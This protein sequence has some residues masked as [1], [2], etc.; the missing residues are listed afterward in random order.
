MTFFEHQTPRGVFLA[1]ALGLATLAA[2]CADVQTGRDPVAIANGVRVTSTGDD[3][4]RLEVQKQFNRRAGGSWEVAD[5]FG[6]IMSDAIVYAAAREG[7]RRGAIAYTLQ[8][9]GSA[10]RGT[11]RSSSGIRLQDMRFNYDMKVDARYFSD[12]ASIPEGAIGVQA[13]FD[14]LGQ[15]AVQ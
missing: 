12:P 5:E 4:A 8:D 2:A 1:F 14:R 7:Q 10:S 13:V 15:P 6:A 11:A 9:A 3:T